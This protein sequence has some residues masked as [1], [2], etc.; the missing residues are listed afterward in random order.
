[1][2]GNR[3]W[4]E[5]VAVPCGYRLDCRIG[6][7]SLQVYRGSREWRLSCSHVDESDAAPDVQIELLKGQSAAEQVE[8]YVCS[9]DNDMLRLRPMLMDRPVVIQPRD[10]VFLPGGED[11]TLFLSTP[12]CLAVEVGDPAVMLRE[13][14]MVRLSDT[15]FGPSTREGEICYSGRTH[16]RHTVEEVPRRQHRALTPAKIRNLAATV[17]PLNKLSLPVPALSVFV[18]GDGSFWTESISLLRTAD[19]DMA[20]LKIEPGAPEYGVNTELISG[21]RREAGRS[22]F[23]RAFST[24]FGN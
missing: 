24:L 12:L 18:S 7:L 1:M 3:K 20:E 23:I 21:P 4:W 2:R 9:G 15:W 5:P 8:R 22:G 14:P 13:V 10:P 11:I 16:A 19:A 17:L 6:P